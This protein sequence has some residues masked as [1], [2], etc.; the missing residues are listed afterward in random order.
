MTVNLPPELERFINQQVAQ[1]V[2]PAAEDAVRAGVEALYEQHLIDQYP[3]DELR[4][5]IQVGID[6]ME[7]GEF[8]EF[9]PMDLLEELDRE[10]DG[11][12]PVI[13]RP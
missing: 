11:D 4:E 2:Y 12:E 1:G 9:D 7:R 10:A 5:L 6:Q 13:V 3:I 8:S